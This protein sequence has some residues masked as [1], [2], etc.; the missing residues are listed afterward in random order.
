MRLMSI[1]A[2]LNALGAESEVELAHCRMQLQS[3]HGRQLE[4]GFDHRA[5]NRRSISDRSPRV[6][7]RLMFAAFNASLRRG[8]CMDSWLGARS[9]PTGGAASPTSSRTVAARGSS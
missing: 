5:G 3:L 9:S 7:A 8:P 2:N 4:C 6:I 1:E